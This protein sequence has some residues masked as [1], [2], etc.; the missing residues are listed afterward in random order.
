MEKNVHIQ[1]VVPGT[2]RLSRHAKVLRLCTSLNASL[3][4]LL[5]FVKNTAVT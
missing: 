4:L 2:Q 5:L 3:F 1:E